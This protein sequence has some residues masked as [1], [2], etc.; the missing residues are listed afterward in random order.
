[1]S[2]WSASVPASR[3]DGWAR[4]TEGEW[5]QA[6]GASG[7]GSLSVSGSKSVPAPAEGAGRSSP[8]VR[9][10]EPRRVTAEDRQG[11]WP[12]RGQGEWVQVSGFRFQGGRRWRRLSPAVRGTEPRGVTAEDRRLSRGTGH[13]EAQDSQDRKHLPDRGH[14]RTREATRSGRMW[15]S[16][17]FGRSL[18]RGTPN[19]ESPPGNRPGQALGNAE[20]DCPLPHQAAK[21]AR[22][23]RHLTR[24]AGS[25]QIENPARCRCQC[26]PERPERLSVS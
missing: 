20:F 12:Q 22:R 11:D 4:K 6:P 16:P 9:R 13:K 1:M 2:P 19:G 24:P 25:T 7:S 10:T 23:A 14:R 5:C 3:F 17:A 21:I 26:G 18:R 15:R 8:A